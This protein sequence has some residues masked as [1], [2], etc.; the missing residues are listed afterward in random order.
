MEGV[1]MKRT[2]NR[3]LARLAMLCVAIILGAIAVAQAQ[4]GMQQQM[5]G[6]ETLQ[7]P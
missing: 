5:A 6:V 3:L 7:R 4:R 1:S 2:M